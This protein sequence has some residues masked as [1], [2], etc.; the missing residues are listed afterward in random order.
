M[1]QLFSGKDTDAYNSAK[2]A[3]GRFASLAIQV[4]GFGRFFIRNTPLFYKI[5]WILSYN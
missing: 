1:S 3:E 2:G 4:V 5:S